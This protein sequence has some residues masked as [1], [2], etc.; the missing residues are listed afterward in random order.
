MSKRCSI[1]ATFIACG[2]PAKRIMLPAT[3]LSCAGL[4][5]LA[6][7]QQD[8]PSQQLVPQAVYTGALT[9]VVS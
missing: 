5:E 8:M 9:Q 1:I 4:D 6:E 7:E 2:T 3:L